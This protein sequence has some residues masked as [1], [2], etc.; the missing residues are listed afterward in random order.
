[1]L[2]SYFL[3]SDIIIVKTTS[4]KEIIPTAPE[5][6]RYLE[7]RRAIVS[8]LADHRPLLLTVMAMAAIVSHEFWL[9]VL[10][11]RFFVFPVFTNRLMM[12]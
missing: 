7:S 3:G 2:C 12:N 4:Y 9:G 6:L 11:L 1:M 5:N 8:D 10:L